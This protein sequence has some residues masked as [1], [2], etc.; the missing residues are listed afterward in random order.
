MTTDDEVEQAIRIH[1]PELTSEAVRAFMHEHPR[2][3]DESDSHAV[4]AAKVLRQRGEGQF[5][6]G[7]P[8]DTV[9]EAMRH[10]D[11]RQS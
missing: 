9:T 5:G 4:W 11:E 8:L 10:H 3:A 2:P 7:A 1:A 6:E